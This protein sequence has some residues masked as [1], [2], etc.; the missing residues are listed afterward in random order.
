[1]HATLRELY[2]ATELRTAEETSMAGV[3]DNL[4]P[5]GLTFPALTRLHIHADTGIGRAILAD[6]VA[7]VRHASTCAPTLRQL[8][9]RAASVEGIDHADVQAGANLGHRELELM[10]APH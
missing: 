8:R 5:P 9:I 3:I 6:Y 10:I 4:L 2:F 7:A 1:M